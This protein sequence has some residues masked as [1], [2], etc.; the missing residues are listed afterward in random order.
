MTIEEKLKG[1]YPDQDFRIGDTVI[2]KGEIL[3]VLDRDLKNINSNYIHPSH[4]INLSYMR[5]QKI[6]NLID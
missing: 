2:L 5:K 3:I 6:K 4:L 1:L